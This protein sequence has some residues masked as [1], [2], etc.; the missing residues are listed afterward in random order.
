MQTIVSGQ[1]A[2]ENATS[3]NIQIQGRNKNKSHLLRNVYAV[4]NFNLPSETLSD[5]RQAKEFS[6]DEIKPY[7]DVNALLLI[8]L[9]HAHLGLP[10]TIIIGCH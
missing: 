4:S 3:F 1:S 10:I 9:E 7:L 8:A 2:I 5:I 6:N